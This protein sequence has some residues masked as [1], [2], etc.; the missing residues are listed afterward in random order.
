MEEAAEQW[1]VISYISIIARTHPFWLLVSEVRWLKHWNFAI[2]TKWAFLSS[3][4]AFSYSNITHPKRCHFLYTHGPRVLR[5]CF[6]K[7]TSDM[8]Y[9]SLSQLLICLATDDLKLCNTLKTENLMVVLITDNL[10]NT[11]EKKRTLFRRH[12]YFNFWTITNY[13]NGSLYQVQLTGQ[14]GNV[15]WVVQ[16]L[17]SRPSTSSRYTKESFSPKTF[18]STVCVCVLPLKQSLR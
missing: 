11:W 5:D 12:S 9:P 13:Q 15:T 3:P 8:K 2:C 10:S 17:E 16:C 18:E 14:Y 6:S 7:K 4:L 1:D